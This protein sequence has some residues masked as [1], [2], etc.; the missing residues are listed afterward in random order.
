MKKREL[1]TKI[2]AGLLIAVMLIGLLPVFASAEESGTA[3]TG[4]LYLS[5]TAELQPDGTWTITLEAYATGTVTVEVK[6]SITPTDIILVLDQSGSMTGDDNMV[7][8]TGSYVQSTASVTNAALVDNTTYYHKV[9][10]TYYLLK[11]ERVDVAG[12]SSYWEYYDAANATA[13]TTPE[14]DPD[15]LINNSWT[16][17][18]N[19]YDFADGTGYYAGQYMVYQLATEKATGSIFGQEFEY[20]AYLYKYVADNSNVPQNVTPSNTGANYTSNLALSALEDLWPGWSVTTSGD[21]ALVYLPATLTT[22]GYYYYKY[23]YTDETGTK[24]YLDGTSET[25][26][27]E[28]NVANASYWGTLYTYQSGGEI[29]RL[30]ALKNAAT[31][32]VNDMEAAAQEHDVD[33]RIAVV[34]FASDNQLEDFDGY[35]NDNTELFIGSTQYN[36]FDANNDQANGGAL[37][38]TMYGQALQ[39]VNTETGKSNLLAS[40]NSLGAHGATYPSYG[41]LM[42]QGI[43]NAYAPTTTVTDTTTNTTTETN[44]YL[45]GTRKLVVVF[46]TDG[47][48]GESA[49]NWDNTEATAAQN[50]AADL[51]SKYGATIYTVALLDSVPTEGG[52]QDNFLHEVTTEGV[53]GTDG[54]RYWLAQDGVSLTNFFHTIEIEVETT[55]TTVTLSQNAY[56][57]DRVS[58]YF[59]MPGLEKQGAEETTED[60]KARVTAWLEKYV[61]IYTA[62]HQGNYEFAPRVEQEVTYDLTVAD[63][64]TDGK[65]HVWPT[66]SDSDNIAHGI[67]VHNFDYLSSDNMVTTASDGA[68]ASGKKLIV[69]IEGIT[70]KDSAAQDIGV[71]TNNDHSG[72]WDMDDA[73]TYGLLEGFP[74]PTALIANRVYV[75]DYAKEALLDTSSS[76]REALALNSEIGSVAYTVTDNGNVYSDTKLQ[77]TGG[78]VNYGDA[79]IKNGKLYYTPMTTN[80]DGYDS[81]YVFWHSNSNDVNAGGGDANTGYGWSKVSVIPANNVYYEDTFVTTATDGTTATG[82]VGIQFGDG[83]DFTTVDTNGDPVEG[84]ND[85]L[86]ENMENGP[87]QDSHGWIDSLADDTGFT[88]GTVAKST[89]I[90]DDAGNPILYK[91]DEEGNFI[92][93]TDGNF[94]PCDKNES[95]EYVGPGS[96]MPHPN[97][98]A[99]FTFTGTGVDIY[100]YTDSTAGT[101][102]VKVK[103]VKLPDGYSVPTRIFIV[104]NYAAS[105][106]YY[107]IPTVSYTARGTQEGVTDEVLVHGTYEV[108]IVVTAAAAIDGGR[109]TYYLDGIRVYNPLSSEQEDDVIVNDGYRDEVHAFFYN[110]RDYLLDAAHFDA[111]HAVSFEANGGSNP[112]DDA[113]NETTVASVNATYEG[114]DVSACPFVA[115]DGKQFKGWSLTADGDI[116]SGTQY[117]TAATILYAIWEDKT[118]TETGTETETEVAPVA[119]ELKLIGRSTNFESGA[120]LIDEVKAGQDS[121]TGTPVNTSVIGIYEDYGPKNEVYLAAGQ[122]IVM[123][124]DYVEGRRWFVSLKS[125][126]GAGTTATV[127]HTDTTK[128]T[129]TVDHTSDLY[130]EVVPVSKD[131][132][133]YI[134]IKNEGTELL[135][136]TKYQITGLDSTPDANALMLLSIGEEEAVTFASTY[137][138]MAS[139]PYSGTGTT[140]ETESE[141]TEDTPAEPETPEVPDVEITNP[142]T[143][144]PDQPSVEE[145]IKNKIEA[146]VE[147][148]FKSVRDWFNY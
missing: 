17:G 100:S 52:N 2:L 7:T 147:R 146:L 132:T 85:E 61:T 53:T 137:S 144:T 91:Q 86:P 28:P 71:P 73:G 128:A 130:Y 129:I 59:N 15:D 119:Y 124:V 143:E 54:E 3:N 26:A 34:G 72:L 95:G 94:V 148:L 104:D 30:Q 120:V 70:A 138:R 127:S 103:P 114:I 102:M 58:E 97:A 51:E 5:K 37:A 75:L 118:E 68:S 49:G 78:K 145:E 79:E 43:A 50:A 23:Y 69:V 134:S 42:A 74:M 13:K 111:Q 115:P 45:K 35:D 55:E 33:H 6:K 38:S 112:T 11:S 99:T 1:L 41:F 21:Y 81:F 135:S 27:A 63:P 10:N 65:I 110:I 136:I 90:T 57:V 116:L 46:M 24:T 82:R 125:P 44:D 56:M 29:T 106:D 32:F 25:S 80:W 107:Q 12:T 84:S 62:D 105:G 123:K 113:G 133:Y 47:E 36:Y 122:Q 117:V 109:V 22:D 20:D 40:I 19:T 108:T 64:E 142:E 39:S 66:F 92:K 9:G 77:T 140:G 101:V 141:S 16:A 131:G 76:V 96:Y 89:Y 60:Y 48:P 14:N 139:V 31:S 4:D 8:T 93:D 18:G 98:K 83:W 126:T 121:V 67:T 88:D 87:A